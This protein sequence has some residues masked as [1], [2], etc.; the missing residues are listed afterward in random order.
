MLTIQ[1]W[2]GHSKKSHLAEQ[3]LSLSTTGCGA[4]QLQWLILTVHALVW[5]T[6]G[7]R[8]LSVHTCK[9]DCMHVGFLSFSF[10]FVFCCCFVFLQLPSLRSVAVPKVS[11]TKVKIKLRV[12]KTG[13]DVEGKQGKSAGTHINTSNHASKHTLAPSQTEIW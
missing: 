9:C 11:S 10:F 2:S 5:G 3:C 8:I 4:E 6:S 12:Q 13:V 7:Y 1:E